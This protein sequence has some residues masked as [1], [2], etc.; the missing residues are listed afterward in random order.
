MTG[1]QTCALPIYELARRCDEEVGELTLQVVALTS[2]MEAQD[3][4]HEAELSR[5]RT[6]ILSLQEETEH[7]ADREAMIW[8]DFAGRVEK[9]LSDGRM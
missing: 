3:M 1:V 4:I 6:E 9:W 5:Y 2:R 8:E 7:A